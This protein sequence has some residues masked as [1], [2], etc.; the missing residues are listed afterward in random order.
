M[1]KSKNELYY[2][3]EQ[4]KIA[5][6]ISNISIRSRIRNFIS[7]NPIWQFQK[8]LRITEY[9]Y[10]SSRGS[11]ILSTIRK[12]FYY[13]HSYKLKKSGINLGFS[14]PINVF[15][16]G[17]SIAHYGTIV[18]NPNTRVGANCRLHVCVN[19]GTSAGGNKAP[20]MGDNLYIAPGCKIFGDITIANNTTISANSVV[21][22][23]F[24]IPNTLIGGIPSKVI[25]YY[26][27][28]NPFTWR[29]KKH[30]NY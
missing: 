11:G 23:S 12:L 24:D 8:K 3:L 13:F 18:V 4:D 29:E 21:N 10:N 14:I 17:L 9:Y 5:L 16:P 2:Y 7:P 26:D 15:G 20:T 25:K 30:I 22:K 28:T 1:I 6:L 27:E 19:I